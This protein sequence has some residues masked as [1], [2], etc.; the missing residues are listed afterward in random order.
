MH[1]HDSKQKIVTLNRMKALKFHI[2]V[3]SRVMPTQ[4]KSSHIYGTKTKISLLYQTITCP[5]IS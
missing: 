1:S 5:I 4:S 3:N 2:H